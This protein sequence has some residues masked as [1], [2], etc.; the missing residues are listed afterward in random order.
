MNLLGRWWVVGSAWAGRGNDACDDV[1][2]LSETK[3]DN[4]LLTLA[5]K[6]RMN[7]E[8]RKRIFCVVMSS[9]VSAFENL[10]LVI[11]RSNIFSQD[12]VSSVSLHA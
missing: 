7:T 9:E 10:L 4:K 11:T 8:L 2:N 12:V 5:K 6:Q 1:K 3:E